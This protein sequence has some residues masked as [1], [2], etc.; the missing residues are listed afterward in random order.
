MNKDENVTK[1]QKIAKYKKQRYI[2]ICVM[3]ERLY[4]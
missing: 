1:L 4:L 2:K 3:F